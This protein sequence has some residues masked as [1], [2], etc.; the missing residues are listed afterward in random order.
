MVYYTI[1]L[2]ILNVKLIPY[3]GLLYDRY[4]KY[5]KQVIFMGAG[6]QNV[7]PGFLE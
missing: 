3:I 5:D 1:I 2:N 6:R 4:T 7:R